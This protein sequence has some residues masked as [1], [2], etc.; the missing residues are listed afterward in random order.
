MDIDDEFLKFIASDAF[1]TGPTCAHERQGSSGDASDFLPQ[2][3]ASG[4]GAVPALRACPSGLL[5]SSP[6]AVSSM[7]PQVLAQP[8]P[9]PGVPSSLLGPQ[10]A[11]LLLRQQQ[12]QG[13]QQLPPAG[14]PS[15]AAAAQAPQLAAGQLTAKSAAARGGQVQPQH[16]HQGKPR[17]FRERQKEEIET[18][19]V[20]LHQKLQL[21]E[22]GNAAG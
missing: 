18:L 5:A 6:A 7:A 22:V 1:T 20:Q 14:M 8:A 17:R 11:L 19:E 3:A 10:T 16:Q 15:A 21:V 13:Q 4:S 9:S 12:E 2:L